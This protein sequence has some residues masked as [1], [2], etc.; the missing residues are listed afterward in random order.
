MQEREELRK[1][2]AEFTGSFML[3]LFAAGSVM[4]SDM[5]DAGPAQIIGGAASGLVLMIIIW[6]FAGVSGGHVNPALTLALA[7]IG[8]FPFRLLP[9][10]IVSQLAGSACAGLCLLWMLGNSGQMGANLPNAGLGI[11]SLQA[12]SIEIVLSFIMMVVIMGAVML[13]DRLKHLAPVPIGAIVGIEVMLFGGIAGAAMNPARAF[14]PFL[15]LGDW[16][17]FWIYLL[18]PVAGITAAAVLFC[19]IF[20]NRPYFLDRK[21]IKQSE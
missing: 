21:S 6:I 14:G 16:Q 5:L 18:G 19:V 15:A 20:L 17:Y 11:G 8:R 7:V 1:Y 12:F 2:A 3:V 13:P 10:Y 9:G 4:A